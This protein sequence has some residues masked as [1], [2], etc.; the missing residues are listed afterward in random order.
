MYRIKVKAGK[1][2]EKSQDSALS[3]VEIY[4]KHRTTFRS[5][6]Y[7]VLM[8]IAWTSLLHAVSEKRSMMIAGLDRLTRA[9]LFDISGRRSVSAVLFVPVRQMNFCPHF[10]LNKEEMCLLFFGSFASGCVY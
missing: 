10:V 1:L 2:L 9:G 5:S 3:A 6:G 8:S 4:N 7:I